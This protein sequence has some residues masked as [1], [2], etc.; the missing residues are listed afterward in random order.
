MNSLSLRRLVETFS[1]NIPSPVDWHPCTSCMLLAEIYAGSPAPSI[2]VFGGCQTFMGRSSGKANGVA[3]LGKST[4]PDSAKKGWT[5]GFMISMLSKTFSLS[6]ARR[7]RRIHLL[8]LTE[9]DWSSIATQLRDPQGSFVSPVLHKAR[10]NLPRQALGVSAGVTKTSTAA[11]HVIVCCRSHK[12]SGLYRIGKCPGDIDICFIA[13]L[14]RA[15][16][17]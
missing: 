12:I 8:S 3:S 13:L 9:I 7:H 14:K 5:H 11:Y 10:S 1:A 16:C 2:S 4:T 17:R 15:I 6:T